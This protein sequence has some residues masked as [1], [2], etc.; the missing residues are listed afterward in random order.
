[1]SHGIPTS[2][3]N[4]RRSISLVSSVATR[5]GFGWNGGLKVCIPL[6]SVVTTLSSPCLDNAKLL[7]SDPRYKTVLIVISTTKPLNTYKTVGDTLSFA[8]NEAS[9]ATEAVIGR[10]N[11]PL[12]VARKRSVL[13]RDVTA[14][15]KAPAIMNSSTLNKFMNQRNLAARQKD[16]MERSSSE[17]EEE[18]D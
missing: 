18:E 4:L 15:F 3:L 16:D 11:K 9:S 8:L 10:T 5:P 1:M 14:L 7:T 6:V 13:K 12:E 2:G 17:E